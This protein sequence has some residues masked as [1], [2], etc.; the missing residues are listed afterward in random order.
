MKE[1][2]DSKYSVDDMYVY[3]MY[4]WHIC[5]VFVVLNYIYIHACAQ[6]LSS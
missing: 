3:I 1:L 6:N 2:A 4:I 5:M